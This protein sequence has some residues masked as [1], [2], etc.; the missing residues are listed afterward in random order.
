[1]PKEKGLT[2]IELLL[3]M[4][5]AA[6]LATIAIPAFN[7]FIIKVRS[8]TVVQQLRTLIYF[9]RQQ[10]ITSG[11]YAVLCPSEDAKKCSKDWSHPIIIFND[12]NKNKII[13]QDE[14]LVKT[15]KLLKHGETLTL[16]ASAGKN[17]LMFSS[18]G[19]THGIFGSFTYCQKAKDTATARK[20]TINRLGRVR[21]NKKPPFAC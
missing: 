6:I 17:H 16:K 7:S 11:T 5:I 12:K 21:Q 2:L 13:D 8:D 1:M 15:S 20:L 4:M 3:S 18:L 19:V 9:T 10:A 14:K